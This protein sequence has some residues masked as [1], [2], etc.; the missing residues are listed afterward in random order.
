MSGDADG[1]ARAIDEAGQHV[2]AEL[3]GAEHELAAPGGIGLGEDLGLAIRGE[4]GG[5]DRH[6]EIGDDHDHAEP[7]AERRAAQGP[8]DQ[9]HLGA[10]CLGQGMSRC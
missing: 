10:P 3:V 2:A 8:P 9:R 4:P 7:G 5:E 6:D 1:V